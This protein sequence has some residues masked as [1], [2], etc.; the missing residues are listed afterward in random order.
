M[1]VKCKQWHC[2]RPAARD[3]A[4]C[5][6]DHAPFARLLDRE[7]V[8]IPENNI[9]KDDQKKKRINVNNS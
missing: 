7:D 3:K 9:S 8:G 2:N 5:C 1:I 4:Y 6:R